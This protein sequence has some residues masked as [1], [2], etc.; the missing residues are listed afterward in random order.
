MA[1]SKNK[2]PDPGELRII[3]GQWR[4]RKLA[5]NPA[6]GLRPTTDRVRETLFNWLAPDIHNARCVDLF[7]GSGALGLEALSRGAAHCDFVDTSRPVLNQI[8][9]HLATLG[10]GTQGNCHWQSAE[11]FLGSNHKPLDIIFV[12]P[13]F[14]LGLVTPI[15]NLL[16]ASIPIAKGASLYIETARSDEL[17]TPGGNWELHRDKKAGEVAY[18]LYHYKNL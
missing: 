12:D 4:G 9:N 5:F 17:P 8:S 6:Q 7:A 16:A 13:P 11:D 10:A 2:R 3:G 1:K 14:G 15:C 18:R